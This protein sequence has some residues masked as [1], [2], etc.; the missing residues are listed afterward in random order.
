MVYFGPQTTKVSSTKQH[1]FLTA[2]F[3]KDKPEDHCVYIFIHI[4]THTPIQTLC[5]IYIILL[6]TLCGRKGIRQKPSGLSQP[7]PVYT[8]QKTKNKTMNKNKNDNEKQKQ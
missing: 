2:I 8:K 1:F 6:L 5:C 3:S 4:R 7:I